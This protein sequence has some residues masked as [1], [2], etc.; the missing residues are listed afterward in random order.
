MLQD[1]E[2]VIR[3]NVAFLEVTLYNVQAQWGAVG[4]K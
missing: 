1:Y 2:E 3:L 4:L